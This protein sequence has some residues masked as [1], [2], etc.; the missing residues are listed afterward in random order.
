MM[1]ALLPMIAMIAPI[2]EES[3]FTTFARVDGWHIAQSQKAKSCAAITHFDGG[4]DLSVHWRPL[5]NRVFFFVSDDSLGWAQ[6]NMTYTLSPMM[7]RGK[8]LD[9]SWGD[10]EGRGSEGGDKP[11]FFFGI[12]GEKAL[13]DFATAEIFG[14][15]H[16]GE[17]AISLRVEA[18]G[19][20][21]AEMKRCGA[22]IK[23]AQ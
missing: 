6:A 4:S 16:D 14:V 22:Q 13:D 17:V 5:D 20:L 23:A 8:E 11:G 7:L 18:P 1:L 21:V 9:A 10:V 15:L 19:K 12:T 2:Q 3:S